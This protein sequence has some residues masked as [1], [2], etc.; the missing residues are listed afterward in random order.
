MVSLNSDDNF[1]AIETARLATEC[2]I[3]NSRVLMH[4]VTS[5]DS[6]EILCLSSKGR[7]QVLANSEDRDNHD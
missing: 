6:A 4:D 2:S 7:V 3:T 1:L 5:G